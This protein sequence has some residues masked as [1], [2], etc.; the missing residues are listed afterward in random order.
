[1]IRQ[2]EFAAAAQNGSLYMIYI[3]RRTGAIRSKALLKILFLNSISE[4]PRSRE[5]PDRLLFNRLLTLYTFP[6]RAGQQ[7]AGQHQC[8]HITVCPQLAGSP[9]FTRRRFCQHRAGRIR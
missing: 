9:E 2:E 1:M 6:S 5:A 4:Y 3:I 8:A 7:V